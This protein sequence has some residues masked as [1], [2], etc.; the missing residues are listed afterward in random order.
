MTFRSQII[1]QSLRQGKSELRTRTVSGVGL[2]AARCSEKEVMS[3]AGQEAK[4]PQPGCPPSLLFPSPEVCGWS[5]YLGRKDPGKHQE[6]PSLE[7]PAGVTPALLS[8]TLVNV[9]NL[10][11]EFQRRKYSGQWSLANITGETS[12]SALWLAEQEC[13]KHTCHLDTQLCQAPSFSL[14]GSAS[15]KYQEVPGYPGCQVQLKEELIWN[16]LQSLKS[17]FDFLPTPTMIYTII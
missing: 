8:D 6:G 2:K 10:F 11:C 9:L 14:E 16:V 17:Y 1:N 7:S 5:P 15:R 13:R 3:L 4:R 12:V